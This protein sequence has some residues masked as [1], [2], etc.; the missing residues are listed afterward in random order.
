MPRTSYYG[1][2]TFMQG[3]ARIYAISNRTR[4]DMQGIGS[5]PSSSYYDLDWDK[6]TRYLDFQETYCIPTK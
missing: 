3:K 5:E 2:V 4:A 1:V 6:M